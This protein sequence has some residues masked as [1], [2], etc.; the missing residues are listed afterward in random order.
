MGMKPIL[1]ATLKKMKAALD[2]PD[3]FV[4]EESDIWPE[5][6]KVLKQVK[7]WLEETEKA[8]AKNPDKELGV[9][10]TWMLHEAPES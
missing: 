7:T 5:K 2:D 1:E 4:P 6:T 10:L 8:Y 9:R 3:K